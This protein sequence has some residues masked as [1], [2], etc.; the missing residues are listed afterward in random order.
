MANIYNVVQMRF[1][2]PILGKLNAFQVHLLLYL[3]IDNGTKSCNF[4]FKH[5][6]A[7]TLGPRHQAEFL[8]EGDDNRGQNPG[9]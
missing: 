2:S 4:L 7:P 1:K 5:A 3:R 9:E 6:N 8:K